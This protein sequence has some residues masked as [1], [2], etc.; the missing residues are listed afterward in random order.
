M[1]FFPQTTLRRV[2]SPFLVLVY[3]IV[4]FVAKVQAAPPEAGKSG[5]ALQAGPRVERNRFFFAGSSGATSFKGLH[6]LDNGEILICGGTDDLGWTGDAPRTVWALP[7]DTAKGAGGTRFGF[8]LRM[9]PDLTRIVGVYHFP[10]GAMEE[11]TRIRST[12]VPG[13]ATGDLYLSGRFSGLSGAEDAY[14][15]GR[16]AGNMVR[17]PASGLAWLFTVSTPGTR[18]R[19]KPE[20]ADYAVLQPWDVRSDGRVI[21][22]EGAPTW[23]KWAAL[24]ILNADGRPGALPGW[25]TEGPNNNFLA[26]KTGRAGSLR[27]TTAEDFN[28]RQDDEND[29]PGRK[30]RYPD[31]YYFS[32]HDSNKGPGYTG[33]RA[34]GYTQLVSQLSIDRRDNSLYFG[35]STQTK[36]PNGV[37]DFEPALVG[38][39]AEGRLLWWARG[40]REIE[41]TAENKDTHPDALNSPPDQYVDHVAVDYKNDRVF[42]VFRSHGG[43]VINFWNGNK[44]VRN[45]PHEGFQNTLQN[46]GNVHVSWLGC[47][48]LRD[49]KIYHSSWIAELSE[50][51]GNLGPPFLSGNLQGWPRPNK[52]WTRQNSTRVQSLAVDDQG[53]PAI[54]AVGRR[55]YTT[56]YALIENVKPGEGKSAWAP[57]LRLYA[58][59]LR[60]LDY[61]TLLRG[62]WDATTGTDTDDKFR[63]HAVLP[64]N[65]GLVVV[66]EHL[67]G[68]SGAIS[69]PP[70]LAPAA[71]GAAQPPGKAASGFVALAMLDDEEADGPAP[72]DMGARPRSL[73]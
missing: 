53:R 36:L 69:A 65:G 48:G 19:D 67:L 4:S 43:N 42:A 16:V 5:G 14:W 7:A 6:R 18:G 21:F 2:F 17:T 44:I 66:G 61:S 70:P 28:H 52:G 72:A 32:S 73:Y 50:G 1:L 68:A 30:G 41:R 11:I 26:L 9:S 12:E 23:H 13:A 55:P 31:D 20:P 46:T 24:R 54:L 3:L 22:T 33:Y 45:Q 37:P 40:Y 58:G 10:K 38:L 51:A 57:F 64:L 29:N 15:I 63:P 25:I 39:N 71:W 56:R 34:T 60:S 62:P 59:N 35:Y 47:Y 27:S 8:V 49:G